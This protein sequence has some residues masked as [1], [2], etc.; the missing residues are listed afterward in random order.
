[1]KCKSP[2]SC[3]WILLI[4]H[5]FATWILKWEIKTFIM[6]PSAFWDIRL[7]LP[8]LERE[9]G[10]INATGRE[11]NYSWLLYRLVHNLYCRTTS[12]HKV[13]EYARSRKRPTNMIAFLLA[14]VAELT[15][16]DTRKILI[17]LYEIYMVKQKLV[18]NASS[19]WWVTNWLKASWQQVLLNGNDNLGRGYI[20]NSMRASSYLFWIRELI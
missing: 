7:Q 5:P 10:R 18:T 1:M 17:S 6:L 2:L 13:E 11:I 14:T 9:A 16:L 8:M 12:L 15:C 3:G 4:H 20:W 19:T